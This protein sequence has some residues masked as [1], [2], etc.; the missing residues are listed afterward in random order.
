[1][2]DNGAVVVEENSVASANGYAVAGGVGAMLVSLA[3]NDSLTFDSNTA[4][5]S[6]YAG[7]GAIKGAASSGY[8]GGV[9]YIT[10]GGTF[11]LMSGKLEYTGTGTK[12]E[13]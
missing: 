5:G 13:L 9:I 3:G 8:Q 12:K 2:I 10:A 1:M 6:R 11:N 4:T 7:G